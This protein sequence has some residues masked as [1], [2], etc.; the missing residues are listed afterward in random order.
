VEA[1]K[2][3][4]HSIE[5]NPHYPIVRLW[6][7]RFLR[8]RGRYDEAFVQIKKGYEEDGLSLP[9]SGN[10]AEMLMV[11]GDV[12][13]AVEQNKKTLEIDPNYWA[14]H[15]GLAYGYLKLGRNA[16]ALAQ[17]QKTTELLNGESLAL[18]NLGYIQAVLGNRAE[19]LS[20]VKKLEE[21]YVMHQA[22]GS[23]VAAVYVGLGEKEKAF[24]WLEKDFRSHA[25]S[26]VYIRLEIPFDSLRDDPRFKD[27]L[28]RM[29]L[30]E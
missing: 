19:A 17:A 11:Q 4:K 25:S 29:N 30:P 7:S 8:S 20:I 26:L 5:L 23:D 6:Y 18:F 28:K 12:N 27:L 9:I 1:E 21:K 14:A 2:E 10:L 22:S 3:F 24:E 13:G 16:E 15:L